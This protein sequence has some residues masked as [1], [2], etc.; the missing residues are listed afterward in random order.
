MTETVTVAARVPVTLRDELDAV[1][2]TDGR[3]KS[4][5]IADALAL[6]LST[7][8][9]NLATPHGEGTTH[10]TAGHGERDGARG[11][12]PDRVLEVLDLIRKADKR[13]RTSPECVE[14]LPKR[15][16]NSTPRRVQDCL[17]RGWIA[18][19]QP[20]P[21]TSDG[22]RYLDAEVFGPGIARDLRDGETLHEDKDGK[23]RVYRRSRYG[24][25]ARV[26]AITPAGRA[27]LDAYKENR[28]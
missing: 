20:G 7:R 2:A 13:G 19:V 3:D 1:V 6:Y 26:Y 16:G 24:R 22:H 5:H 21:V 10:G 9:E 28:P 27:A 18:D 25:P 12:R 23:H 17:D 14:L 11:S 15:P 8:R 4:S